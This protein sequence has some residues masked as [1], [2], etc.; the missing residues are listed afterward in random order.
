MG[1]RSRVEHAWRI[2]GGL[3][4][5]DQEQEAGENAARILLRNMNRVSPAA[6]RSA[7]GQH[8]LERAAHSV[9]GASVAGAGAAC[10]AVASA[11]LAPVSVG[12]VR[13]FS[14]MRADFPL[15]PRR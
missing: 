14:A 13:L 6:K 7:P 3:L 15:R 2:R 9:A 8:T 5:K 4:K 10:A 12:R 1:H 11:A